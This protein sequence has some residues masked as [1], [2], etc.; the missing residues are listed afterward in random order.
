M[1]FRFTSLMFLIVLA[2]VER[3]AQAAI[4]KSHLFT[5]TDKQFSGREY[6]SHLALA[7]GA[8]WIVYPLTQPRIL[9]GELGSWHEYKENLGKV[10]FDHDEPRWNWLTHPIAGSQLYLFYRS[11]GHDRR[12]S[13]MMTFISSALF[14]FTIETYSEPASLQ[15]LYQT[16]VLGTALGCGIEV[17]STNLLS[18]DSNVVRFL[19]RLVNPF[20]L[21]VDQSFVS[22]GPVTDFRSRFG[23]KL[24]MDF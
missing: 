3:P 4:S 9:R 2:G 5:Y 22:L 7:Y 20:S 1:I 17:I 13:F 19:G 12:N 15:D 10:V 16:P 14:E 21:L 6:F 18:R 24:V 8:S 11:L 23:V